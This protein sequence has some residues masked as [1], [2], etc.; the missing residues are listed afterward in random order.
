LESFGVLLA[1]R[2]GANAESA[3]HPQNLLQA[4][5]D[6]VA[7]PLNRCADQPQDRSNPRRNTRLQPSYPHSGFRP[8]IHTGV[9]SLASIQI[10]Y[11]VNWLTDL[12]FNVSVVV[13]SN[14]SDVAGNVDDLSHMMPLRLAQ[15]VE[16]RG[17][18]EGEARYFVTV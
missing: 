1:Q 9:V 18:A 17:F 8:S 7:S 13:H 5:I 15:L 2:R 14:A 11:L 10:C 3:V 12:L 16:S 4:L 6:P